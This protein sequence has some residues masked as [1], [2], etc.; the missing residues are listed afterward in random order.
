MPRWQLPLVW[1]V[2]GLAEPA[3]LTRSPA[4]SALLAHHAVTPQGPLGTDSS[5]PNRD[6]QRED[7]KKKGYEKTRGSRSQK[8]R[9]SDS[10]TDYTLL[11]PVPWDKGWS[12]VIRPAPL[13]QPQQPKAV[14]A[15]LLP[16]H[17]VSGQILRWR[18]IRWRWKH[19]H[20]FG[21]RGHFTTSLA[22]PSG[23]ARESLFQKTLQ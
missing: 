8:N 3:G 22:Q 11:S 14:T 19:P 6:T 5:V 1:G 2:R 23:W 13:L 16:H 9:T 4:G 18:K 7:K 21:A 12:T 20:S 10:T 15:G 17:H